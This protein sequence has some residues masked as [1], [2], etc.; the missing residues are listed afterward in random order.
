MEDVKQIT[1]SKRVFDAVCAMAERRHVSA[2]MFAEEILKGYVTGHEEAYGSDKRHFG[3]KRVIMPAM[4]FDRAEDA[5][6]GRY[7]ATTIADISLG[8]TRLS[9][10]LEKGAS[11]QFVQTDESFEILFS[12]PGSSGLASFKCKTRRVDRQGQSIQVGV[13][14]EGTDEQSHDLLKKYMM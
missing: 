10:P 7:V 4:V 3:R 6:A 13:C 9:I 12:L 8:G 14:F 2:D 5:D 1:V 11:M